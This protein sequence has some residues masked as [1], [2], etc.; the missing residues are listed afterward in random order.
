[1]VGTEISLTQEEAGSNHAKDGNEGDGKG[2]VR[3][4]GGYIAFVHVTKNGRRS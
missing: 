3:E 2:K 1:M 4:R